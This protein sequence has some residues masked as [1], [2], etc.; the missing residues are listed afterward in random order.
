[1]PRASAAVLALLLTAT[2]LV[3]STGQAHAD[4]EPPGDQPLP[5]YTISNPPLAPIV[6]DGHE[7][8]VRQGVREHAAY[9]LEVPEHWNG[10]L[11]MW[12]HGYRGNS[13][14]LYPE[15]PGFELRRTFLEQGYAWAASSYSTNGYDVGAGVRSTQDLATYA[16]SVLPHRATRT[17]V[18]G[19]SMG[20]HVIA[21][22]LEQYPGLYDGALPM[23]G[24]LG[25]VEL[26]DYF[27]D[28]N[29][30][31]QTLARHDAYPYP[32]DYQD[33]DVP[34]IKDRLGL[35]GALTPEGEQLRAL[36]I[37]RSGGQRPGVEAAFELWKDYLFTFG[38]ADDGGTLGFNIGRVASNR[39]SVYTPNTPVDLDAEIER[40]DAADP[41]ARN[42]RRLNEPSRIAGR[43]TAPVVSLHNLG[44]IFVPYSLEQSYA[45][46][47]ARHHRSDLLVQ[48][49]IRSADHCEF[50]PAEAS[51]AWNDLV[52]W[53]EHGDRPAGDDVLD[54]AA[55]ADADHGCAFTDAAA[56]GTGTRGLYEPCP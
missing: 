3:A 43:P 23:C 47:A 51:A 18:T 33:V 26:F 37:E 36:T 30:A 42:S 8:S 39:D 17:Y 29:L 4:P 35:D 46:K 2:A 49:G 5:G 22:S 38:L 11:V 50:S 31:A 27:L 16:T 52:D 44:D 55:V 7:T 19:V 24:Q 48:R 53:V 34:L 54:P 56:Y 28:Y 32:A 1:M 15:T 13:Y 6:V 21:R 41:A 10:E 25:D 12:A 40:A 14:E 20:G 45:R 9:I